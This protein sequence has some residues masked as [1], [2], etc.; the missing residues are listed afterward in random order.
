MPHFAF[1][2]LQPRTVAY[3]ASIKKVMVSKT[4]GSDGVRYQ[5]RLAIEQSNDPNA[6]LEIM[7]FSFQSQEAADTVV[8]LLEGYC[9]EAIGAAIQDN[10]Y[11]VGSSSANPIHRVSRDIFLP[12][13]C[14]Y[15]Y[16]GRAVHGHLFGC[17]LIYHTVCCFSVIRQMSA[18]G[19]S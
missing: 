2:Y 19:D 16:D 3:F 9:G 5:V 13:G 14:P 7:T 17:H 15:R 6:P 1:Y 12:N 10:G 8:H 18:L 4:V 11:D